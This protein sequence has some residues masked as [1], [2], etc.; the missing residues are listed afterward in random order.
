[1]PS[2]LLDTI[3]IDLVRRLYE[4]GLYLLFAVIFVRSWMKRGRGITVRELVF[5]F[6]LSQG[7]EFLAVGMGRYRYPDWVVYFPPAPAW[8]PLSI[9][10]GWA[11]L[12][13]NVM[14]V[15]ET[16]LGPAAPF[17]RLA[18]LDGLLGVGVDL[19]LDPAVSGEPLRMWVWRGEGMYPYRYWLLDVPVFNFVGWVL[20]VGACTLQLRLVEK[21]RTGVDRWKWLGIYLVID[22]GVAF[23]VML[24]PW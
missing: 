16:I 14:R 5:G 3:G 4:F 24:L 1:M 22:L 21:N 2:E 9:G 20:L 7:V 17:W 6:L 19:V 15:S 23:A 18:L 13:P 10:L 8:V 12:V 11:A